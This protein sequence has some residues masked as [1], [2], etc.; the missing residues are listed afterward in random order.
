M[1]AVFGDAVTTPCPVVLQGHDD[2]YWLHSARRG[3]PEQRRCDDSGVL[4]DEVA[5]TRPPA[6]TKM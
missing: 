1:R 4:S 2:T 5:T 3:V 6:G